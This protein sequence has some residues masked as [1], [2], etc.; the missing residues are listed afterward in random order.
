VLAAEQPDAAGR[1]QASDADVAE[2]ARAHAQPVRLEHAGDLTPA[3]AGA[4]ADLSGAR[5]DDVDA[6]VLAEVEDDPPSLV[7]RPPIPCPPLRMASGTSCARAYASAS[8]ASLGVRGRR[9]TGTHQQKANACMIGS[10]RF[11]V[12]PG[13]AATVG[14]C[15]RARRGSV[16]QP[17]M[18]A[19]GIST[20]TKP[21]SAQA[22]QAS[23]HQR[24]PAARIAFGTSPTARQPCPRLLHLK[25]SQGQS[26]APLMSNSSESRTRSR[27]PRGSAS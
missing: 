15:C 18:L 17:G 1:G 20:D 21:T 9:T 27:S 22:T 24:T 4:E 23:R 13:D 2:V 14:R 11:A 6:V 16:R 10:A 3:G 25:Q 19:A 8:A 5:V 7:E 26:R 12:R